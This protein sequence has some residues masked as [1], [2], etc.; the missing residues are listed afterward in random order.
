[1]GWGFSQATWLFDVRMNGRQQ[2]RLPARIDKIADA[3][4]V[5]VPAWR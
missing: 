2:M 3:L 4:A 5:N 1:M